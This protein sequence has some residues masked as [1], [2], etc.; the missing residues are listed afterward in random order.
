M[1]EYMVDYTESFEK[2]EQ[3]KVEATSK[4]K[5]IEMVK[6]MINERNRVFYVHGVQK[7]TD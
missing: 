1:A 4:D 6:V 2:R 3:I 5:A 7:V